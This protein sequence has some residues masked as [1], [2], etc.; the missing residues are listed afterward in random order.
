MKLKKEFLTIDHILNNGSIERHTKTRRQMFEDISKG[1]VDISSYRVLCR[2]CNSGRA[3]LEARNEPSK[4]IHSF[5]GELCKKCG[6]TKVVR[7]GRCKKYGIRT[8]SRCPHCE[9]TASLSIRI[10]AISMFGGKCICCSQSEYHKL[11]F[12]HMN[13]DGAMTRSIDHCGTTY[14]YKQLLRGSLDSNLYQLLCWNCNFSKH[15]GGGVCIHQR[16][17]VG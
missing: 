8:Y 13:N 12:D 2:N 1:R 4:S 15:L 11:T 17:Q 14:F 10:D 6:R 9:R 16:G 3:N 7:R 5:L